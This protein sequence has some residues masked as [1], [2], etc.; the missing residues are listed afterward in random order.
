MNSSDPE[1]D[2]GTSDIGDIFIIIFITVVKFSIH[3]SF[4][5]IIDIEVL[6][7]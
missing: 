7:K 6:I 1:A 2:Q 4:A 5:D 3:Y